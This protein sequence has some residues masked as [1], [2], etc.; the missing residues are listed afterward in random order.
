MKS[1]G[2][3]PARWKS[4]RFPGKSLCLISGKPMLQRV[5]EQSEKTKTLEKIIV[6]TDDSR[7]FDFVNSLKKPNVFPIITKKSHSTG[8]DRIAEIAEK[9]DAENIINIQGDEPLIDPE[10]IDE[11]C[12][13][14]NKGEWDMSSAAT[15][16]KDESE[17]NNP[18]VVKV[19]FDHNCKALYFSRLPIPFNRDDENLK[20]YYWK[21]VGIYGYRKK[22]LLKMS[23]SPPCLLEKY[24]K[25]E[26]LRAL[27]LGGKLCIIKTKH[28]SI[29]VDTPNDILK[30]EKIIN[31]SRN[32]D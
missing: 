10:L 18:S 15:I 5:I 29:G 21:H 3:I 25:L 1:V 17:F 30:V 22:F 8:T 19:V 9:I 11:I 20:S 31:E 27:H 6:A 4:T 28:Q 14:L 2:I 26:Q 7:I 32:Y 16:I 12:I 23:S 24:E 13:P